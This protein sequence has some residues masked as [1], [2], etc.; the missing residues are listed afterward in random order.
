MGYKYKN[1]LKIAEQLDLLLDRLGLSY[2]DS[3][4]YYGWSLGM[5][6]QYVEQSISAYVASQRKSRKG[7]HYVF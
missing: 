1:K 6:Y 7:K 4:S 2:K 5:R 3:D